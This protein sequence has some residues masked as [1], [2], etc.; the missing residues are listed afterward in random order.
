[1]L[2]GEK[3]LAIAVARGGSKGLPR[4]NV[5]PLGDKPLVAWTV[6]AALKSQHVDRVI[7]SS[8]D[9]EIIAAARSAGCEVPFVR[10]AALASD[11]TSMLDVVHDAV[12][13]CGEGF[14]WIVL[15]Q[16]TSPLRQAA[17]IDAAL[18]ACVSAGAPACVTVT[19]VDKN[20][21]W[22]FLRSADGH[23]SPVLDGV[24]PAFRR[25]DLAQAYVLNGAV[26]VARR[27]WLVGRNTFLSAETVCH[28][29]PRERSIDID[30]HLDFAIAKILLSENRNEPL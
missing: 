14:T 22:M 8:D 28:V 12:A 19:P 17:D 25:Q 27:D 9:E 20:P 4:K 21:A 30:T 18:R 24:S 6:A 15:L 26:Y 23:M 2:H 13:R 3:V 11:T 10:G 7:L 16:A 5:L 1:M 29:M